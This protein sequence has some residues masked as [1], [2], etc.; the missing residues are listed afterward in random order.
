MTKG[1]LDAAEEVV[2]GLAI[3][4][5]AVSLARVGQH[6]AEDMSFMA[7]AVGCDNWSAGTEV[8]LGLIPGL[9]FKAPEGKF[10]HRL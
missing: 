4:C 3:D 8:D 10:L 2:G 9:T 1:I 6:D 5:L 7:L